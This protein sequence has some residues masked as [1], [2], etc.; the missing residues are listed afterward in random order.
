MN[1]GTTNERWDFFLAHVGADSQTAVALYEALSQKARVFLDE[2]SML[3]GDP[4]TRMLPAVL[5]QSRIIVVLVS[6]HTRTAWYQDS[7]I[8]IALD[9][10]R[11]YPDRYRVIA[12]MLDE[13]APIHRSDLP[14]GLEQTVPLSFATCGSL[15][16]VVQRLPD[17][18]NSDEGSLS[19]G[20]AESISL[21]DGVTAFVGEADKGPTWPMRLTSWDDFARYYGQMANLERT[22]LPLAVRGFFE[23]GGERAYVAR[24]VARDAARAAVRVPTDNSEQ[25]LVFTARSTGVDGNRALVRIRP[26][27]RI[28]IRITIGAVPEIGVAPPFAVEPGSPQVIMEDFD[29]LSLGTAGP[30]P[31]LAVVNARSE[32]VSVEWS[33]PWRSDAMPRAG[34]WGLTGGTDGRS[35]VEDYVGTPEVPAQQRRGL[36]AV[37]SLDDV[38][39][40]C[41]PDATHPRFSLS[42]QEVLTASIVAHCERY[43]SFGILS[44]RPD[45]DGE[46]VP[47]APAD[48]SAAA[49]YLPWIR[50]P[51]LEGGMSVLVPPVGHI[52]LTPRVDALPAR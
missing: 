15:Q 51:S 48:T 33:Q 32:L 18:L 4:W 26:G 5:R 49:V 47:T 25:H 24:V 42:E 10:L 14:Y 46:T 13:A 1:Q 31:L 6:P 27:S 16:K 43:K 12:M 36:A 3:P 45:Q 11:D 37:A 21:I 30:N 9:L 50:V 2:R 17:T 38:A 34:E 20:E 8:R 19:G 22:Y 41:V 29:N 44:T 35:M 28:G 39:I 23:N 40:V 7:E 52:P